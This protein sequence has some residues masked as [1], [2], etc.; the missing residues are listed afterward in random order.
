MES[1]ESYFYNN[2]NEYNNTAYTGETIPMTPSSISSSK[3]ENFS[4]KQETSLFDLN[5]NININ[6][7]IEILKEK[8]KINIFDVEEKKPKEEEYNKNLNEIIINEIYS[9]D[10]EK[11]TKKRKKVSFSSEEPKNKIKELR[12]SGN[13]SFHKSMRGGTFV[14]NKAGNSIY[15]NNKNLRIS[16]A[17]KTLMGNDLFRKTRISITN[18]NS[19]N[20]NNKIINKKKIE[21]NIK[22]F[23]KLENMFL[24]DEE[25]LRAP[26]SFPDEEETNYL[27]KLNF[28]EE[29]NYFEDDNIINNEYIDK[30]LFRQTNSI[31]Y[32]SNLEKNNYSKFLY[33]KND[34]I[35]NNI[36][37]EEEN[38]EINNNNRKRDR[39]TTLDNSFK[40]LYDN[41]EEIPGKN[42]LYAENVKV[43]NN[44][45]EGK[46]NRSLVTNE[47]ESKIAYISINLFIKKV[48]LHNFRVMY[49]L[50]YKAFLQQYKIFLSVPLFIEKIMKAFEFHYYNDNKITDELVSLL[51]KVI[52]EN[53][54][55]IKDDL[56]LLEKIKNFYLYIKENIYTGI[57]S[58]LE[59]EIDNLYYILFISDSEED[60]DFSRRFISDRKKSNSIFM[61]SKPLYSNIFNKMKNGNE[62]KPK[63]KL[64]FRNKTSSNINYKYFYIFNHEPMEIAEYLTCISYQ[65]MRNINETELLNK[66]FAGKEKL[67]KAP[68]V[69]KMIDRTNKLV[70]F[71]IED[72]FSYDNKKSRAQCLEKWADVALKLQELHNYN[73]LVMINMCFVNCTLNK[74][75]L[76]FKKLSNKYKTI[77][78][79]MNGFCSSKECYVNIRKLIFNCKGIPYI[80]YLGIILKEIINIEEMKYIIDGNNINFGKVV[81]L[82]NV[83]TKFNEFKRSKFSF[84]KSK[85]LDILMNLKPKT[86]DELDE[87]VSQIEP[88]LKIFAMR[89][90]KKRLTNTDRFYYYDKKP[91]ER[92]EQNQ[93]KE[94]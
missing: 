61:K 35:I 87:M 20:N 34:N 39:I 14:M 81:K 82:Y 6:D 15:D 17:R 25:F 48:A 22:N 65:M 83:I 89:G 45:E 75:K 3:I 29:S 1:I 91:T 12:K 42:I 94:K 70:L 52:S 60:I 86:Q 79:E 77:I 13:K 44:F 33:K 62:K 30:H 71:I 73:D 28:L 38:E 72:I 74:L 78:K 46:F 41:E 58:A 88:K 5:D 4:A 51:N 57:E 68:N 40:N 18:F 92:I 66:N 59:Q 27:L 24:D 10:E 21:N 37:E 50:L 53:Y 56:I 80:P 64:F 8:R 69:M 9:N 7:E 32:N 36:I 55:K 84:E 16:K 76:T 49:P 26:G 11:K 93:Q 47:N 54:E 85:Q 90:F 31:S 63:K 67:E 2:P 19:I 23:V 43:T